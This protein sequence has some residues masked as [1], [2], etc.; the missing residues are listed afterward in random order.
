MITFRSAR[1]CSAF[2]RFIQ[3][4]CAFLL[5]I[6]LAGSG[7]SC[8]PT[9]KK[10]VPKQAE[11]QP[12]TTQE[13]DAETDLPPINPALPTLFIA[14]DSTAAR[15]H[16]DDTQGWAVPFA[17]YFDPG[18]IN[19]LNL[20]RGGR[21]SRTFITEGWWDKLLARVKPGDIVLIQF[22]HNDATA[23]DSSQARGSLPGIGG[24]TQDIT[25]KLTGK[26]ETVHTFGWYV[27][28]MIGDTKA[29]GATP[30]VLSL[31]LHNTWHN[32]QVE[33]GPGEFA[34][35]GAELAKETGVNF[36]DLS[37]LEADTFQELGPQRMGK[38][39][40]GKT[41]FTAT[42]ADLHARFVVVGL[43]RL[44]GELVEPFLSDAGRTAVKEY[45]DTKRLPV[46]ERR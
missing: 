32:G 8:T 42:A 19:V 34:K 9:D 22:G 46:T 28:R 31:T 23:I 36:V 41:H 4:A 43:E 17:D 14:S 44:P 10:P 11:M 12:A 45:R 5:L 40:R 7:I 21:S 26:A 16:S 30:M 18:K 13:A 15:S 37:A 33:R 2:C 29:K 6:G 35:W 1:A 24:E 20:A 38:L 39:Y 25:N 3:D 27:R